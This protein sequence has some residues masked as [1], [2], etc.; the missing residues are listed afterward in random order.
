M[1]GLVPAILA[2]I[3]F[4]KDATPVSKHPMDMAGSSPIGANISPVG[5]PSL[6]QATEARVNANNAKGRK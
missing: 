5:P 4:A 2:R 1:A 6:Q 3:K